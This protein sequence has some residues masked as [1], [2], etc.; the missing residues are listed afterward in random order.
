MSAIWK[1]Q[2]FGEILL[3]VVNLKTLEKC[4]TLIEETKHNH[5]F[6]MYL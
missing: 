3:C 2:S 5:I 1:H 6:V 4:V